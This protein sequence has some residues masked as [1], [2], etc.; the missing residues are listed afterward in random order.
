[1]TKQMTIRGIPDEVARRLAKLGKDRDQSVNAIVLDILKRAFDVDERRAHLEKYATWSDEDLS[2]F[3]E[4]LAAQR[5]IDEKL[6][7]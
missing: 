5:V 6:W 2:E 1:M 4:A 3:K 7:R